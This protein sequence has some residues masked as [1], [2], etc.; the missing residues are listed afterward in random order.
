[1][2]L[3]CMVK[4][5]HF[6]MVNK[7]RSISVFIDFFFIIEYWIEAHEFA[8]FPVYFVAYFPKCPSVG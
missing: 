7:L 4:C 2:V 8:L 5:K 3:I 6:F 1:M